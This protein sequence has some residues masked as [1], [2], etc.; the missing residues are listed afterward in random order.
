MSRCKSKATTPTTRQSPHGFNRTPTRPAWK[1][2]DPRRQVSWLTA[3][4]VRP[5]FPTGEPGQWHC[6][7]TSPFTVAGAAAASYSGGRKFS[8]PST[9]FPFH[10]RAPRHTREPSRASTQ[11]DAR[12]SRQSGEVQYSPCAAYRSRSAEPT[13]PAISRRRTRC[14]RSSATTSAS[15]LREASSPRA[16]GGRAPTTISPGLSV[17]LIDEDDERA[18]TDVRRIRFHHLARQLCRAEDEVLCMP[19]ELLGRAD[20]GAGAIEHPGDAAGVVD[21]EAAL[22][23]GVG[24]VELDVLE[25]AGLRFREEFRRRTRRT[26]DT[27]ARQ[28]GRAAKVS[29]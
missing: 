15:A 21:D 4:A 17:A 9:A 22:D 7:Q 8:P 1:S 25:A 23:H 10:P 11:P 26:G 6:G 16:V 29:R 27:Q 28:S 18:E 20:I 13:L 2:S 5:T 3:R 12:R 24:E 14:L 19:I